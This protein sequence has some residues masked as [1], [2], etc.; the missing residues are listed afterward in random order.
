M[1]NREEIK[2]GD[3][4]QSKNG[5]QREVV[6]ILVRG[7]YKR[8]SWK[9]VYRANGFPSAGSMDLKNFAQWAEKKVENTA[10]G[11][12]VDKD[13]QIVNLRVALIAKGLTVDAIDAIQYGR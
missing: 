5:L 10:E 9:G 4:Y 6:G 1:V 2:V 3:I 8:L 12:E 13:Q 11:A 7:S